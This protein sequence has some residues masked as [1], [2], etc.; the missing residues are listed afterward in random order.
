[1]SHYQI[2]YGKLVNAMKLGD[3]EAMKLYAQM[4]GFIKQ[5][6]TVGQQTNM[7]VNT[8]MLNKKLLGDKDDQEEG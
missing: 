4:R 8:F 1:M 2:F 3:I 6:Q 5:G 7:L